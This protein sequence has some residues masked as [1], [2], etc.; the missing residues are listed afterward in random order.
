MPDAIRTHDLQSRSLTLYPAELRARVNDKGGKAALIF[1]V[2]LK[3]VIKPEETYI[4]S[5][6][7]PVTFSLFDKC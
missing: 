1:L 6:V 3:C 4:K 7:K 5:F 2:I